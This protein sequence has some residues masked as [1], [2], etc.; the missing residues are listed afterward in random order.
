MLLI[1]LIAV[2]F[3]RRGGNRGGACSNLDQTVK[4]QLFEDALK[5]FDTTSDGPDTLYCYFNAKGRDN[6]WPHAPAS[7]EETNAEGRRKGAH[8]RGAVNFNQGTSP[9]IQ[10]A[11][12]ENREWTHTCY[13]G[14]EL[15]LTVNSMTKSWEETDGTRR[16]LGRGSRGSPLRDMRVELSMSQ[17]STEGFAEPTDMTITCK[18][19]ANENSEGDCVLSKLHCYRGRYSITEGE[20]TKDYKFGMTC[21]SDPGTRT[22]ESRVF[23]NADECP[24]T[25]AL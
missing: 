9:A 22:W 19:M 1:T 15:K 3:A 20:E 12:K 8:N 25:I 24:S 13:Q 18:G 6:D 7:E 4:E 17:T 21:V 16:L 11:T 2:A 14:S 23:Q 5:A 10:V